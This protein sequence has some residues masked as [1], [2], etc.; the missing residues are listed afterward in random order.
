MSAWRI[1]SEGASW[2]SRTSCAGWLVVAGAEAGLAEAETD[3]VGV[4]MA[5]EV[6]PFEVASFR[7]MTGVSCVGAES[8][9][10]LQGRKEL[11][12]KGVPNLPGREAVFFFVNAE[13]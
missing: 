8:L 6:F 13:R 11:S 4:V 5:N 3:M 2:V 7:A 1:I 10:R 12:M 9:G